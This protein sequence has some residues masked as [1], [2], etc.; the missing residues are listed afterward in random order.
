MSHSSHLVCRLVILASRRCSYQSEHVCVFSE[1]SEHQGQLSPGVLA[2]CT[3]WIQPQ[4]RNNR[5]CKACSARGPSAVGGPK[6]ARRCFFKVFFG[7]EGALLEYLHAGPLQPC[8]ATAQPL[9]FFHVVV[10]LLRRAFLSRR[11]FVV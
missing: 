6:F 10:I 11:R 7:E 2:A 4:R 5:A 1:P 9:R 3:V 8:Y